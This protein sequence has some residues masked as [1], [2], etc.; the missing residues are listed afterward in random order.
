MIKELSYVIYD[1]SVTKDQQNVKNGLNI[2]DNDIF[3]RVK[4]YNIPA[5][6]ILKYVKT[7]S[8]IRYK[9]IK[10]EKTFA[11]A[12]W[13]LILLE[14]IKYYTF[15]IKEDYLTL[16][17]STDRTDE[18]G[19]DIDNIKPFIECAKNFGYSDF[20]YE[21]LTL[22]FIKMTS[23]DAQ[24]FISQME[25]IL[26]INGIYKTIYGRNFIDQASDL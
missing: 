3:D 5:I 7:Q 8:E 24:S 23:K 17:F 18:N 25:E 4:G 15:T 22:F 21:T 13:N 12:I 9:L 2:S 26:F 16:H 10:F 14:D 19:E 1:Y 20:V 6:N 11:L